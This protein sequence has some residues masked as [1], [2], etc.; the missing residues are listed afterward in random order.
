MRHVRTILTALFTASLL[1]LAGPAFA[2]PYGQS[3]S[4]GDNIK[5]KA[6]YSAPIGYLKP[7]AS[8]SYSHNLKP[9]L[10][11][12]ETE[13]F[14]LILDEAYSAGQ[15][16]VKI[17]AE[18]AISLFTPADQLRIDMSDGDSHV[19][20]VSVTANGNGRHYINVR[21]LTDKGEPRIFGIAVQVGA[22]TASKPNANMK[23]MPNG[24]TLI[25][26]DAQE[27]VK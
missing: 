19:I 17:A 27:V 25:L 22:P 13:T 14:Q 23:L 2:K 9:R 5:L 3:H 4:H 6:G 11:I 26:M 8:V 16:D 15:L 20:D 1:G 18:G 10:E 21:A 12:G 24:E 7:G